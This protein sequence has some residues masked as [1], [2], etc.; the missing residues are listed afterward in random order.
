MTILAGSYPNIMRLHLKVKGTP[1]NYFPSQGEKTK[2]K[3]PVR[4]TAEKKGKVATGVLH[5][6]VRNPGAIL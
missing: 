3:F 5:A 6:V 1:T 4:E 2:S